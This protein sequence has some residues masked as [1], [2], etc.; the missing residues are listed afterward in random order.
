MNLFNHDAL[1]DYITKQIANTILPLQQRIIELE[2]KQV[3]EYMSKKEV[4]DYLG[5]TT[6]TIDSY[7]KCGLPKIKVSSRKSLFLR[8]DVDS[9]MIIKRA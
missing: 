4:A 7:V 8:A 9:F 1:S 3:P 6:S 2:Q 5:C